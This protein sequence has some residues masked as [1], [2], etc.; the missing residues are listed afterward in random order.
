[1]KRC[2]KCVTALWFS[3]WWKEIAQVA[4][5]TQQQ[6]CVGAVGAGAEKHREIQ[7]RAEERAGEVELM[8]KPGFTPWV[9]VMKSSL[10]GWTHI[11]GADKTSPACVTLL[12]SS[13]ATV[14][15]TI[16]VTIWQRNCRLWDQEISIW[17]PQSQFCRGLGAA[18]WWWQEL[19]STDTVDLGSVTNP[20]GRAFSW[21]WA[22]MCKSCSI[23]QVFPPTN[24]I[25]KHFRN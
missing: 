17:A 10:G 18:R 21:G 12:E 11:L 1:M 13:D 25:Y 7:A 6:R 22:C 4:A 16:A 15:A 8:G 23:Q 19:N 9:T 24:G 5:K 20:Q 2:P 3:V 14:W